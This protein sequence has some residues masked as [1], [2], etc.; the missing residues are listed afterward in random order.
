VLYTIN[1][2][3]V[4]MSQHIIILVYI[5]FLSRYALPPTIYEAKLCKI[6]INFAVG[7]EHVSVLFFYV[8]SE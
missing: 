4:F 3:R 7:A 8:T 5:D 2:F 1:N 6:Y